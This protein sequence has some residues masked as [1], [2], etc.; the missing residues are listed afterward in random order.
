MEKL[1]AI[2]LK[3]DFPPELI[4]NFDETMLDASGHKV[5][6]LV[7]STD[8]KPFTEN[9]AKLKHM[10][11]GLCVSASGSYVRPLLI[12]PLKNLPPL[13]PQV[14]TFFSFS[15]QLNGF[16]DNSIWHEWVKNVL[17]PH[18]NKIRQQLGKP[19]Q[20]ALFI[21][22]S[23]S[24]RKH[25]P[26]ILLFEENNICVIIL[27]AHSSTILQPLDLSVNGELKRLL[28]IRFKPKDGEDTPTKRN[29]LLYATVECLQGAF[30][31]MVITDGFARAGIFPFSKEA[32]LKSD[33]VKHAH[34]EIDFS[35]SSKRGKGTTIAGKVLTVGDLPLPSITT[36]TSPIP[37]LPGP[38]SLGIVPLNPAP[39]IT[40]APNFLPSLNDFL[41]M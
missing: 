9:E 26:T 37:L 38:P 39:S 34:D 31:G 17:I 41:N 3:Y 15:G 29:R 23:H 12:L 4:F 14:T 32:P 30:L 25:Q 36:S 6:V 19:N 20:K 18:I 8:P 33:L 35:P 13:L 22:D 1:E 5:K 28:R 16:I 24:T 27:P 11:L 7:R 10:S 2:L 21:V 40:P